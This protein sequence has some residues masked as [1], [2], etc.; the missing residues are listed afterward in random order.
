MA[1]E[2]PGFFDGE[3]DYG[4][5]E[6][7][8]METDIHKDIYRISQKINIFLQF[9]TISTNI[10]HL[11]V[12]LQ[13]ELRSGAIYILMTGI[14]FCDI[15][16]FLL[17]FYNIGIER[18]WW[19][20]PFSFIAYCLDFKYM[21]VSPFHYSI[22]LII[23]ITRP[24]ATWLAIL[25]A[26]I[27]TLSVM[28]PMSN[29]IQNMTKSR[30]VVFTIFAV[31]GFWM[32]FYSWSLVLH[33]VVW[34]PDVLY[35]DCIYY[36]EHSKFKKY[37]FV[38]P[39]EY[40]ELQF[41]QDTWD[42]YTKF[43]PTLLYP[44]LTIA[45]L[46]Q[47]RAIKKKREN[48]QKN[49]LSDR[50][51]KTTK[52]ILAMTVCL[53]L[54][55]GL[56]GLVGLLIQIEAAKLAEDYTEEEAEWV[57][58][59]LCD[60]S[61]ITVKS[62]SK[63]SRALLGSLS[64]ICKN[65]VTFNASTHP[66]FCFIMSSQYRDTVK[67]MF[68]KAKKKKFTI[69]IMESVNFPMFQKS[70]QLVMVQKN[71]Y[72]NSTGGIYLT[73]SDNMVHP[74]MAASGRETI[75]SKTPLF[76]NILS[77][78]SEFTNEFKMEAL[79]EG[80]DPM[81]YPKIPILEVLNLKNGFLDKNGAMTIEYGFHFDSFFDQIQKIWKFNLKSKIFDCESK[82]NMISYKG[83]KIMY[84]HKQLILFHDTH[85]KIYNGKNMI[86]IMEIPNTIKMEYFE[87][88]LQIAHGVQLKLYGKDT[89]QFSE[90][91]SINR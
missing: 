53:M 65:L 49:S 15:I 90:K 39:S 76:L 24:T 2:E 56:S 55:E 68:C 35:K 86:D 71:G 37:I 13:K 84:S 7:Y 58:L 57:S 23:R 12:L 66:F 36:K 60:R 20:N 77:E 25:M 51:D 63:S 64:F 78:N 1:S 28:F 46:F 75:P 80:K 89:S 6:Y 42:H 70:L 67:G 59:E 17:D 50:S 87:N 85:S 29:W 83:N 72:S 44:I 54:S 74:T 33:R 5:D 48:V 10:F 9:L 69:L 61:W 14:C 62:P 73:S 45:L 8:N 11:I 79:A 91:K 26:L 19:S 47:L 30:N 40:A 38:I 16:N 27:R 81:C 52:L 3:T 88:F 82:K 34:Y 32:L 21:H 4:Y 22:Q 18:I 31:F 41:K 43:V